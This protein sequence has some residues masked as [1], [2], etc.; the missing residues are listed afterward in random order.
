M[1]SHPFSQAPDFSL[2]Y[3][4]YGAQN[5][6]DFLKVLHHVH[7]AGSLIIPICSQ[8]NKPVHITGPS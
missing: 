7:G 2:D 1:V 6:V 4:G 5:Q 8:K 3:V